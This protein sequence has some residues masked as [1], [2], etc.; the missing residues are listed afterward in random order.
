MERDLYAIQKLMEGHNFESVDEMNAYL[1]QV[2]PK[3]NIPEWSPETPLEQAQELIY[4]ALESTEKKDRIRLAMEALNIYQDCVDA[5]VLLAEGAA[6]TLEQAKDW[7][8]RGVE[9]GERTLGPEIF[10]EEVGHFWGL[11]ETRPYMR[12]R[13]GLA[14]SLSLLGE[15][16]T[17]IGHYQDMLRL[18][19]GDNQGIRYKLL[20]YLMASND[21]DAAQELLGQYEDEASAAWLFTQVLATFIGQ[22]DSPEA[23]KQLREAIEYNPHVVPYLLGRRRMPHTIPDYIGL[24]DKDEAAAYVADLGAC[25]LDTPGALKWLR[26]QVPQPLH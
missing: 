14:D 17:A 8:Q 20:S 12:A 2:I 23:R 24:G 18:N 26:S 19:P 15:H 4:Q 25:W 11:I 16:E 1:N 21:I 6:E 10:I 5:Y 22:G 7:Y 13:E 3:G 9:A